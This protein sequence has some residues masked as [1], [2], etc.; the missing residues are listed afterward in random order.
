MPDTRS[1]ARASSPS[2]P[3]NPASPP[4]G[5]ATT[6]VHVPNDRP[7]ASSPVRSPLYHP[8]YAPTGQAALSSIAIQSI[9][10]G[11]LLGTSL[12]LTLSLLLLTTST[13]WRVP[14]F[15]ALCALFHFLEFYSTARWNS[16]QADKT[17][18]LIVANGAAQ[19]IAYVVALIEVLV[20]EVGRARGWWD[21]MWEWLAWAGSGWAVALGLVLVVVGQG[22]R[23]MA[24]REAGASF[25]H[26]GRLDVVGGC[27]GEG[28]SA[29]G[30]GSAV[31][32]EE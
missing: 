22:A 30:V 32:Q 25:N 15:L 31:S 2:P 11:V 13:L 9:L 16:A 10:L 8:R 28:E 23:S 18:F 29:N 19:G 14:F 12:S 7:R 24:M 20:R 17:S 5:S 4:N 6:S 1:R 3:V 27:V 21:G 26:L